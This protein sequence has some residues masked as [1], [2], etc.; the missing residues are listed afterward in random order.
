[1]WESLL[2][3][4]PS[5]GGCHDLSASLLQIEIALYYL[6]MNLNLISSF[7]T[8]LNDCC[9]CD[10]TVESHDLRL[11][12]ILVVKIFLARTESQRGVQECI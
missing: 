1:M 5:V 9:G 2:M 11:P 10:I 12:S 7:S 4:L 3:Q 6:N 8:N